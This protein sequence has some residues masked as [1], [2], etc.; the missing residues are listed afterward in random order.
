MIE[1]G[2]WPRLGTAL[3]STLLAVQGGAFTGIAIAMD[4]ETTWQDLALVEQGIPPSMHAPRPALFG[5]GF[6]SILA[7][8]VVLV[9]ER[10]RVL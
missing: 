6:P 2:T 4:S 8:I 3:L 7:S 5:I 10:R 1:H 9:K